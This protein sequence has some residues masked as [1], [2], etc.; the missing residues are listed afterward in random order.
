M[1]SRSNKK[2]RYIKRTFLNDPNDEY[3]SQAYFIGRVE[4]LSSYKSRGGGSV[5]N[6]KV[7]FEFS[8]CNNVVSLWFDMTTVKDVHNSLYKI[9]TLRRELVEF[10]DALEAELN[11][12]LQRLQERVVRRGRKRKEAEVA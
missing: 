9:R 8:D 4:D 11:L 2:W 12:K 6:P 5:P 3:H 10:C 7:A 1:S